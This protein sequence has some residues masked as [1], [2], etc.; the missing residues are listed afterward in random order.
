MANDAV[1]KN[2]IQKANTLSF[3]SPNALLAIQQG[4]LFCTVWPFRVKGPFLREFF[5]R[6]LRFSPILKNQHFQIPVRLGI[7]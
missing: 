5:L 7:G 2:I 4:G 1:G 6:V 3:Q